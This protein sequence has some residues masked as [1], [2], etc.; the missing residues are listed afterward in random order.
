MNKLFT[1]AYA[2]E[3]GNLPMAS[4]SLNGAAPVGAYIKLDQQSSQTAAEK[5]KVIQQEERFRRPSRA[6]KPIPRPKLHETTVNDRGSF[7][8]FVN[9]LRE[10]LLEHGQE[11]ENITLPE[12][13]EA[14]QD[15][16][17]DINVHYRVED[18]PNRLTEEKPSWRHFA[19]VLLG[20]RINIRER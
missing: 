3:S 14:L 8:R 16:A 6:L 18:S 7:A 17:L 1:S 2:R 15:S 11:W 20:A 19:D 5:V 10:D 9:E 12:F 13:L 4:H